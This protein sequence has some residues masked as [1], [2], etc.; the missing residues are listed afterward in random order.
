MKK[1]IL[2]LGLIATIASAHASTND[3]TEIQKNLKAQFE[4]Q[5]SATYNNLEKFLNASKQKVYFGQNRELELYA[6]GKPAGGGGAI[7]D[8]IKDT[9]KALKTAKMANYKEETMRDQNAYDFLEH[10]QSLIK[11]HND[12]VK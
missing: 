8:I 12:K 9:Y 2:L 7:F 1:Q 5:V 10:V 4:K 6:R 3:L 11:S